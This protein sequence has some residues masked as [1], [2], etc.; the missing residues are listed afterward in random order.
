MANMELIESIHR[1]D[2][3]IADTRARIKVLADTRR[4]NVEELDEF[5]ELELLMEEVRNARGRLN[6]AMKDDSTISDIDAELVE[7]RFKFNDLKEMLSHHLV[8]YNK[9]AEATF[10]D[11]TGSEKVRPIVLSAKLGKPEYH[12]EELFKSEGKPV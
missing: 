3:D 10:V 2:Q 7:E 9:E 4:A 11:I 6:A 1:I 8:L 12:Q 5:K